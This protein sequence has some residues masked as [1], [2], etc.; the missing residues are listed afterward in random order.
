[1]NTFNPY[2]I[3]YHQ[4]AE[5]EE[6]VMG[7]SQGSDDPFEILSALEEEFGIPLIDLCVD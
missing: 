4:S 3:S 5:L 7:L 2:E 1:M 6:I